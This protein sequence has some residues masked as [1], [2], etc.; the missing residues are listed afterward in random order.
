ML[1]CYKIDHIRTRRCMISE[2]G[3]IGRLEE[4]EDHSKF[5]QILILRFLRTLL[6]TPYD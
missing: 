6:E 4:M 3:L 2:T 5:V 1:R